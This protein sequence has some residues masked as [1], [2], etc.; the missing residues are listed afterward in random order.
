MAATL[1]E[2]NKVTSVKALFMVPTKFALK[3]HQYITGYDLNISQAIISIS[4]RL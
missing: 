4:H 3:A 2:T 1:S